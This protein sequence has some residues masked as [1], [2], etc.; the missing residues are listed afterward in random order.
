MS[1]SAP[2][3]VAKYIAASLHWGK[4]CG[5]CLK[6]KERMWRKAASP[7]RKD[8]KICTDQKKVWIHQQL[9]PCSLQYCTIRANCCYSNKEGISK[10]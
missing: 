5:H 1:R 2:A 4:N 6:K 9:V 3:K 8:R 7:I 10:V